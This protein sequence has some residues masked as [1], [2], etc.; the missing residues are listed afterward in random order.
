M[1]SHIGTFPFGQPIR[2]VCQKDRTPK[3]VFVLGVYVSA[4]HARW[5]D[6]HGKTRIRAVAVGSEPEIFWRGGKAKELIDRIPIPA[7]AG[8]LLPA[9]DRLNG[10]SGISLD[11]K[12]LLPLGFKDRADVWLCDLVPN[13]C[14]NERQKAALRR[15][16]DRRVNQGLPE[17][18]WP[19]VPNSLSDNKRVHEILEEFHLASP[20]VMITLG[21][22][23]LKWFVGKLSGT[24]NQ[25][26]ADYGE[27]FETYGSLH[28][29]F[30]DGRSLKLLPL[31]HPRQAGK[32][33]SHSQKWAE[34]HDNW[35]KSKAPEILCKL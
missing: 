17:Y 11:E 13:S 7:G 20:S 29:I 34:L 24:K 27:T 23:P 31:V 22:Q 6:E 28:D 35:M 8:K 5:V 10:P 33:G 32:L 26:L 12:F 14:C 21:D 18:D 16:Y 19:A 25:R 9:D 1:N 15:E 3:K 4:V 2:K 30:I